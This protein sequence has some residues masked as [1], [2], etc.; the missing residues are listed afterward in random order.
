ML[1]NFGTALSREQMKNVLGGYGEAIDDLDPVGVSCECKN[2]KSAGM[3][4]CDTCERYCSIDNEF[5]G[6]ANCS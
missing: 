6:K 3:K 1:Q 5:G 2:G 4:V